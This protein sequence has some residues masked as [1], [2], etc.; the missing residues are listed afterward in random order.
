MTLKYLDDEVTDEEMRQLNLQ[1]VAHQH[2]MEQDVQQPTTPL[3]FQQPQDPVQT[4]AQEEDRYILDGQN[5][6]LSQVSQKQTAYLPD[7]IPR[8]RMQIPY[9]SEFFGTHW[10]LVQKRHLCNVCY[11]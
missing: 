3:P 7:G 5:T 2:M 8:F 11:L 1:A 4:Q 9:L 10:Y 6:R